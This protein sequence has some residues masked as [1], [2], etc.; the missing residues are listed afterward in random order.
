[1]GRWLTWVV[2]L[3]VEGVDIDDESLRELAGR[4]GGRD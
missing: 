4:A 3:E 2:V 1:M